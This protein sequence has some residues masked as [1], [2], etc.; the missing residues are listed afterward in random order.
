MTAEHSNTTIQTEFE[1]IKETVAAHF[2]LED[3]L[4]EHGIPTFY[5]KKPQETKQSFL[6]LLKALEPLGLMAVLRKT[7][8]KLVLKILQKPPSRPSNVL[9]NWLLLFAT[10][11]TT[12][13]TGYILSEDFTDPLVGGATFTVA[14]MAVLG[15]H[16]IGHKLTANREGI[17]ATPPYFIPGP[18]PLG[19][20]LGIGTFGAVIMQKSLPPNK[21]SLFDIGIS[22]P[23]FGFIISTIVTLIGIPFSSYEWIKPDT[24]TL[25]PLLLFRVALH[26]IQ[27]QNLVPEPPGPEYTLAIRLHP[28]A[29]AGWVGLFVTMLNLMPAAMLDGGHVARSLFGEKTRTILTILSIVFLA[30]VSLPM[31]LF[32]MFMSIF[33]HPGPLDDVSELSTGRKL[34]VVVLVA[35]F[36]LSSFLYDLIYAFILFLREIF[37]V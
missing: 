33:R 5:L 22:G 20:F 18:P 36:V 12:F 3:A 19:R 13:I 30:C 10:I 29:F 24:S 31:A 15:L 26:F 16:E 17:E 34:L 28:V 7:D 37:P 21:D 1:K 27:P 14:I 4:V 23:I 35:I 11:G 2:Q 8:G 9:V 6:R 25:P 32:V